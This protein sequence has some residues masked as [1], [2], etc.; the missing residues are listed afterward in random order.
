MRIAFWTKACWFD[1][2]RE[3]VMAKGTVHID[4][5]KDMRIFV[6]RPAHFDIRKTSLKGIT[7]NASEEGIMVE[8]VLPLETAAEMFRSLGE[9]P[10]YW[11][12]L[13][14]TI[15]EDTYFTEAEVKHYHLDSSSGERFILR[16]GFGFS[17]NATAMRV[18]HRSSR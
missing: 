6:N 13:Y 18:A 14:V 10:N 17:R 7:V 12:S 5:R 2:K 8:S 4:R 9:E 15:E 16:V 11:T 1:Q 3:I